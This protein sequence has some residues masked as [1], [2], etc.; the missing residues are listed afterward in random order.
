MRTKCV[1]MLPIRRERERAAQIRTEWKRT[2]LSDYKVT[3][4]ELPNGKWACFLH[5]PGHAVPYNLGKEF[6]TEDRAEVWLNVS[7]ATTS[8]DMLLAKHRS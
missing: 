3:V 4:E 5:I 2:M 6:K 7:E 8:I 1:L